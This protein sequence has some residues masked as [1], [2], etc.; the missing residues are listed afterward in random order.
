MGEMVNGESSLCLNRV[1]MISIAVIGLGSESMIDVL[2][3]E[4]VLDVSSC[5]VADGFHVWLP[6]MEG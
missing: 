5:L 6:F 2:P 3:M 1:P 4:S